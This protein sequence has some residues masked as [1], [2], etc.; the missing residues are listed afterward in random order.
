MNQ[1]FL[2]FY[3]VDCASNI[4]VNPRWGASGMGRKE[5]CHFPH[6]GLC[7]RYRL[8]GLIHVWLCGSLPFLNDFKKNTKILGKPRK[9][10]HMSPAPSNHLIDTEVHISLVPLTDC[11]NNH[12]AL[13]IQSFCPVP[14]ATAVSTLTHNFSIFY[15]CCLNIQYG[16]SNH[17]TL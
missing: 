2:L 6:A 4:L 16:Y 10:S 17:T 8:N 7:D 13:R 12:Q 9:H 5:N 1:S 3:R 15:L 14:Q 11:I